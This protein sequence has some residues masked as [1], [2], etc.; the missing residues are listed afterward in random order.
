MPEES[1]FCKKCGGCEYRLY[2]LTSNDCSMVEP[3]G[4]WKSI[5]QNMY[6][7]FECPKHEEL[8][9]ISMKDVKRLNPPAIGTLLSTCMPHY[10][11][12]LFKKM[13]GE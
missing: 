3:A 6:L 8:G 4:G 5:P 1:E 10:R 2:P 9:T 12:T 7:P 11:V 13:K